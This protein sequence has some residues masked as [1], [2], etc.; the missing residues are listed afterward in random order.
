[1]KSLA[2]ALCILLA[3]CRP[4]DDLRLY[5]GISS[6]QNWP[7]PYLIE[8]RAGKVTIRVAQQIPNGNEWF[9]WGD[10]VKTTEVTQK[11]IHF[12]C[13]WGVIGKALQVDCVLNFDKIADDGFD[14]TLT[15]GSFEE[16][17]TRLMRFTRTS[18]DQLSPAF[19]AERIQEAQGVPLN[20]CPAASSS[21]HDNTTFNQQ[22]KPRPLAGVR[23]L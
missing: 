13:P 2:I 4:S 1:M 10:A 8:E 7:H 16:D 23:G 11:S 21:R 12:N 20:T 22:S 17:K 9:S 15:I 5:T 6:D 3:A 18:E 19:K 14:A